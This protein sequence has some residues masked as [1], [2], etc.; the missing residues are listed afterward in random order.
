[1]PYKRIKKKYKATGYY[2]YR[3]LNQLKNKRKYHQNQLTSINSQI[4]KLKNK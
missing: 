1:M 4:K 2:S 3:K